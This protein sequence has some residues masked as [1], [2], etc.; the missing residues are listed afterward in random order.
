MINRLRRPS[1]TYTNSRKSPPGD[2]HIH[3]ESYTCLYTFMYTY[4]Y[5]YYCVYVCMY[6]RGYACMYVCMYVLSAVCLFVWPAGYL[7]ASIYLSIVSSI[8]LAFFRRTQA[9]SLAL[10][11]LNMCIH[12]FSHKL[13]LVSRHF[14]DHSPS[15]RSPFS[16]WIS[17]AGAGTSQ[18]NSDKTR[19][20]NGSSPELP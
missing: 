16:L 12:V 8:C 15:W 2:V 4:T 18:R 6:V 17:L 20:K 10:S 3:T 1:C 11:L 7:Y 9:L 14:D 5:M 19:G 13:L